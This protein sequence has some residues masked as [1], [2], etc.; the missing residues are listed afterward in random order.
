MRKAK[1]LLPWHPLGIRQGDN[2]VILNGDDKGKSGRV[3]RVMSRRNKVVVEGIN[4]VVKHRKM[5]RNTAAA[6]QT[7]RVEMPAPIDRAKVMLVCPSCGQPTKIKM[8]KADERRVRACKRCA[9]TV[10]AN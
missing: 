6:M 10:D 4:M 1:P 7:G 3:V 5:A 8:V 9:A 2:V